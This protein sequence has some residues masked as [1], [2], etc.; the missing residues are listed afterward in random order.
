MKN[1]VR[2]ISAL[3][4]LAFCGITI[5]YTSFKSNILS[6]PKMTIEYK[7]KP[8]SIERKIIN[9]NIRI[10]NYNLSEIYLAKGLVDIIS[11]KCIDQDGNQIPYSNSEDIITIGPLASNIEYIDFSYNTILGKIKD[12]KAQG[13]MYEDLIVF[14]GENVML[15]PLINEN[16]ELDNINE[17][18]QKISIE[19]EIE[20]DWNSVMPFQKNINQDSK[21]IINNPDWYIFYNLAKSCYAFGK[22]EP[23]TIRTIDGTYNFFVDAAYKEKLTSENVSAIANIYDYYVQIFGKGL[24]DY[25]AVLLRSELSEDLPILGGVGGKSLGISLDMKTGEDWYTFSHTLYHAFFDSKIHARNLHF[26]PNLW[27]YKG[28]A[29]Y[30]VDNS[31]AVVPSSIRDKCGITVSDNLDSLYTRYLYFTLKEPLLRV[32]PANEG[33]M[34]IAQSEYYY[35]TKVPLIINEIENMAQRRNGTANNLINLLMKYSNET[36]INFA[37]IM[38]ELLGSDEAKVRAYL[39]DEEIL[40]YSGERAKEEDVEE[41][42]LELDRYERYLTS[43]FRIEIDEYPYDP[44]ILLKP[45]EILK[46]VQN[47]NLSFGPEQ[48]QE[49]VKNYSETVYLLLMQHFLRADIC[50][51]NDLSSSEIRLKLNNSENIK[52]WSKYVQEVGLYGSR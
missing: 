33:H 29:E 31:S 36:D 28:L 51:E 17:Y 21:V 22:F 13:D 11:S 27:L 24:V 52:K 50:G 1:K 18:I 37:S 8:E 12:G 6:S 15:F 3:V 2:F 47:R 32:S 39:A 40:P 20:D 10:Y 46:E 48:M 41:N 25:A 14:S 7:I 35:Y 45:E 42:L 19:V 44:V 43:L 5:F 30:Y 9:T 26:P 16:K 49:M 38:T 4:I 23:L 34:L